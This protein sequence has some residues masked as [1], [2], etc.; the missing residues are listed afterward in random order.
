MDKIEKYNI[1]KGHNIHYRFNEL[2]KIERIWKIP[3]KLH[4]K[5][6]VGDIVSVLFKPK[7][8]EKL[9]MNQVFITGIVEDYEHKEDFIVRTIL[10][11]VSKVKTEKIKQSLNGIEKYL[12]NT[13]SPAKELADKCNLSEKSIQGLLKKYNEENVKKAIDMFLATDDK[14]APLKFLKFILEKI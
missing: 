14:K 7:N 9:K 12:G 5:L 11:K 10:Q 8:E 4:N 2:D 3:K 13:I 1:I 6:K